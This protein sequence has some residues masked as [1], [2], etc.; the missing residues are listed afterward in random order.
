M[1]KNNNKENIINNKRVDN[2]EI[3]NNNTNNF[4]DLLNKIEKLKNFKDNNND[5]QNYK[6]KIEIELNDTK[7]RLQKTENELKN[8][9]RITPRQ[10]N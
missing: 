9:K 6:I 3:N 4:A 5:F 8:P 2:E 7:N 10:K 1:T